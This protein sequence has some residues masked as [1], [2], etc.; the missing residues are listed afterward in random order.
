MHKFYGQFQPQVDRFIYER[1]FRD[2]GIRGIFVECGA[3]DGLTENSC[4]FFEETLGWKGFNIEPVPWVYEKLLVNR[5][6][7][8]NLNFA[9]SSKVGT[10]TFHAVDHPDFGVDCTNGSLAH[11]QKHLSILE[12]G[13][14]KFIDVEVNLLTWPEFISR[15]GIEHVD[16]LV[17]DVEGHE[18]SV[19]AGMQGCAVLPGVLCIEV[20]HLDLYE[21]R[22]KVAELG[23]IY[24]VSSHVNA[25]FIRCDLVPLFAFRSAH[26][27]EFP[28]PV[29]P[30]EQVASAVSAPVL[31]LPDTSAQDKAVA[32]LTA[33]NEQLLS[34]L[35]NV[36][37]HLAELSSL[38]DSIVS[39]KAWKLIERVRSLRR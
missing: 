31:S 17:L 4:K 22:S 6:D 10:A 34:E 14:C 24:D 30:L 3:F 35:K 8:T 28:S 1:Y 20:G 5:P 37:V 23:Y 11:T 16:L 29:V 32:L 18:L 19:I 36:R 15:N 33:K 38:Y 13:G 9:L 25:F 7:S 21:I 39:S 2:E 27:K 12:E 26:F